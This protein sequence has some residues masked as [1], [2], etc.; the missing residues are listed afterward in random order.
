MEGVRRR[1]LRTRRAQSLQFRIEEPW[2]WAS[3]QHLEELE[4]NVQAAV[5][6]SEDLREAQGPALSIDRG[7]IPVGEGAHHLGRLVAGEENLAPQG[8]A[9]DLDEVRGQMRDIAHRLVLDLAVLPVAAAQEVCLVYPVFI[10]TTGSYH[11]YRSTP[12]GHEQK[13]AHYQR[14]RKTY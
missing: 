8:P 10:L 9:A 1:Y 6:P 7:H 12:A 14:A 3:S 4:R 13:M 5:T 2:C 11:I